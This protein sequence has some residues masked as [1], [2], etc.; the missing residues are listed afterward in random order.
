MTKKEV[1]QGILLTNKDG[2]WA[3]S[4]RPGPAQG[5]PSPKW[6]GRAG[7]KLAKVLPSPNPFMK[8]AAHGLPVGTRKAQNPLG[9]HGLPTGRLWA[10]VKKNN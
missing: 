3:G 4:G 8:W 5:S 9:T 7:L 10:S 2:K 6:A 1:L